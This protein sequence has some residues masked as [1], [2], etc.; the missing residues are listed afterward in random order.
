MMYW[1]QTAMSIIDFI[2]PFLFKDQNSKP[3]ALMIKQCDSQWYN[4]VLSHVCM[5][6]PSRGLDSI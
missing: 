3:A 2:Q 1:T 6:L 4:R 5:K